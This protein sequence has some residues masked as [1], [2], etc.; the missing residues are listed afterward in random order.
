MQLF[1]TVEALGLSL[2][3]AAVLT[4]VWEKPWQNW[5]LS[6]GRKPHPEINTETISEERT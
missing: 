1:L 6:W 3:L 4:Y 2:L 5:I